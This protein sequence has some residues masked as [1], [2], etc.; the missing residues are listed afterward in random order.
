[1]AAAAILKNYKNRDIS[2]TV[3]PILMKFINLF[4][5]QFHLMGQLATADTCAIHI[6]LLTY[7]LT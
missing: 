4:T 6:L 5:A 1:M 7:L 3:L 2:A